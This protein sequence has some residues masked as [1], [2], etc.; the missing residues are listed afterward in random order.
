[1]KI[2]SSTSFCTMSAGSRRDATATAKS[3]G[4]ARGAPPASPNIAAVNG[5]LGTN[6]M[7]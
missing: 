6:T 1:M 2:S 4:T 7:S 3:L 5:S